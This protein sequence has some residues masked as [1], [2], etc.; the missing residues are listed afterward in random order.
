MLE[1]Y[2]CFIAGTSLTHNKLAN[3]AAFHRI[4]VDS[5]NAHTKTWL[6]EKD[7]AEASSIKVTLTKNMVIAN[8]HRFR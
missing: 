8:D 7:L 1:T 6:F 2:S 3:E 4:P 5:R